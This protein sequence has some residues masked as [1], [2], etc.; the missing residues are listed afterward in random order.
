MKF[1]QLLR[2][3]EEKQG[4]DLY[5][6]ADQPPHLKISGQLEPLAEFPPLNE[7][8][9]VGIA[10]QLLDEKQLRLLQSNLEMDIS[11]VMD[12]DLR[13]RI[14]FFYQQG[15]L[16]LVIR[17]IRREAQTFAELGLPVQVMEKLSLEPRGLV[18]MAG[19]AGSGK[20][21]TLAA[22]LNYINKKKKKHIITVE[23]PIEFTYKEDKC[24]INQ[25]EVG[26]D[27]HS[28]K[29][30][31]KYV[32]RQAPDIIVIGEMRDLE[33]MN[34]AIMIAEVGHLVLS[35]LHTIDVTQTLER[36]INFF[37]PFQH[38]QIRMQLSFV[39]RGVVAQRL[40]VRK[41]GQGRIPACEIL[42]PTPTVRKLIME[43]STEELHRVIEEGQLFGMQTFN[44]SI[45]KLYQ[46]GKITYEEA[47]ENADNPE[48]LELAIKGIYTGQDTFRTH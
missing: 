8:D 7:E 31:M 44:Q 40:L 19:A 13:F 21:T 6:K 17:R 1:E 14:N 46:D 36:I 39:L 12:D 41:D 24:L 45:L 20:T 42:L 34:S 38:D 4:S 16:A 25:R 47:M 28:F 48:L 22:M 30:A 2:L 35:S 26:F 23:D 43:G 33:T 9:V 29:G 37:P 10:T 5:L 32:I 15:S 11:Y 18:L 3:L 27:T